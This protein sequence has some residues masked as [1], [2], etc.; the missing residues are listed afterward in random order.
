MSLS[1]EDTDTYWCVQQC[2]LKQKTQR[3]RKE[4]VDLPIGHVDLNSRRP[5]RLCKCTACKRK[6]L[7]ELAED[8]REAAAEAERAGE[9][10]KQRKVWGMKDFNCLLLPTSL[11]AD[12]ATGIMCARISSL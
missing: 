10:A 5:G 3:C 6:T 4:P 9:T 7:D 12:V 1:D 11:M 2:R 8:E